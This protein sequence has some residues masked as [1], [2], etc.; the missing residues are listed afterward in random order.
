[1]LEA[2]KLKK[3]MLQWNCVGLVCYVLTQCFSHGYVYNVFDE[4]VKVKLELVV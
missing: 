1:M 2:L 3:S 4:W